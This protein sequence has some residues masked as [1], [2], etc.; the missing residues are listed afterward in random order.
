MER[1]VT[2]GRTLGCRFE[3]IVVREGPRRI[4]PVIGIGSR[5]LK[6]IEGGPLKEKQLNGGRIPA[7]I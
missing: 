6:A 4:F 5:D 3:C 2:I 1:L 7:Q